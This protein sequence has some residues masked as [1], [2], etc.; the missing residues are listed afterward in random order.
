M[1]D[2]RIFLL[3]LAALS[4]CTDKA[5]RSPSSTH[6]KRMAITMDDFH[7][8]FDIGLD[9]KT[10]HRNILN[11][12]DVV[13]HKAAG[14]VTGEF[15]DTKWG[16]EV[17]QDWLKEGHLIANHTWTHP[18]AEETDSLDYVSEIRRNQNYLDGIKGTSGFFRFPFLDDGR[19]RQQQLTLFEAL[20]DLGLRNA[21]VTIDSVDWFTSGRLED[22]L[23]VNPDLDLT[24]YR[25]YYI[26][27][28][29]TLSNHWD[30]VAQTLGF[31]SLPHLM[32]MHHNVLNGHFLEDVLLAL[33]ADGWIFIDAAEALEFSPY[34]PTPHEPNAGRNWLT[35][36][37]REMRMNIS[38]YPKQYRM[39]GRKEMDAL[40]L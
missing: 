18:Y 40:G 14:F 32:L 1:M 35:L 24:P 36:K 34:H 9:T 39:F 29:V 3:G 26:K 8:G 22:A 23:K 30:V 38:R 6:Q 31:E 7:L 10:R 17:V 28:C 12:F 4:A 25:D 2:R 13:G 11:A 15:V 5:Q 19:D 27:M 21:P 37:S 16:Q 20:N 33:K